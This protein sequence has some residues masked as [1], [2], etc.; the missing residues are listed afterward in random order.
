MRLLFA[1]LVLATA[2]PAHAEIYRSVGPNG[3]TVFSDQPPQTLPP[4]A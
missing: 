3:Q 4:S 2:L 1:T